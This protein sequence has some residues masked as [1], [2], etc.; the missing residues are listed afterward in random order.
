MLQAMLHGKLT[1]PEEGMED[2]LTSNTFGLL[3]Y[4]PVD[5][6]LL[7]FLR[8]ARNPLTG[9]FLAEMLCGKICAVSWQFW[10][11]AEFED[12]SK[13]EPDVEIVLCDDRKRYFGLFIE[14]KY[15][16]GKSSFANLELAR[17]ADQLAKELDNLR[18]MATNRRFEDYAVV[19]VTADFT[20]PIADIQ[21]SAA[22]Y[23]TNRNHEA[24]IYWQSWR[25]LPDLLLGVPMPFSEMAADL[26]Q[27]LLKLGLTS[28]NRL[29]FQGLCAPNWGF[30]GATSPRESVPTTFSWNWLAKPPEWSFDFQGDREEA[31]NLRQT[32][33]FNL[34]MPR[35]DVLYSWR[36]QK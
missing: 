1:R 31:N 32:F 8:G 5:A 12:C 6:A 21:A 2:L 27:L 16:S 3:K 23:E 22:D 35:L 10:P 24:K 34:A 33:S 36:R 28:F 19:Y 20:C 13:C 29:R 15:R 17:P 25:N 4:L 14:A 9:R 11:N 30:I 7:P 18:R 26:R